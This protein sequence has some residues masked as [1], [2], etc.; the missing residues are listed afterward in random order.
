MTEYK[1]RRLRG[2]DASF[3]R[4]IRLEALVSHPEAFGAS[5][6]DEQNKSLESIADRLERGYVLGGISDGGVL[7]GVSQNLLQSKLSILDR[8]GECMSARWHEGLDFHENCLPRSLKKLERRYVRFAYVS[9]L[10][11][12]QL[13][14]SINR[15]A[16][17]NGLSRSKL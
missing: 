5:W 9:F 13:S 6:E 11:T 17:R 3:F 8:F 10:P 2:D 14:G 7:T 16:S 15:W 1:L 4:E 12:K